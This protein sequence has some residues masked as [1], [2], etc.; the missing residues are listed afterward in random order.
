MKLH[1]LFLLLF[2]SVSWSQE[3][4]TEDYAKKHNYL[5]VIGDTLGTNNK[6]K[7]ITFA[8][9]PHGK[10]GI[11]TLIQMNIK[12]PNTLEKP[13]N[14]G[15]VLL[16][17]IVNRE[18]NIENVTVLESAGKLFDDEA[19]AVLMKMERW[20]PGAVNGEAVDVAYRQPFRFN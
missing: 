1:Y 16:S 15:R 7:R 9:Y 14:N 19:I 3:W 18:G 12:H 17:Y 4:P 20:I 6:L 5:E 8:Q 13:L 10:K 2:C 11:N